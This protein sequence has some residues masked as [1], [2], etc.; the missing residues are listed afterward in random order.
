[1]EAHDVLED[2]DDARL[3]ALRS[4]GQPLKCLR[5]DQLEPGDDEICPDLTAPANAKH[6][7]AVDMRAALETTND[8]VEDRNQLDADL[9]HGYS[10]GYADEMPEADVRFGTE[11]DDREDY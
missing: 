10:R 8:D 6:L 9:A 2:Q 5:C 1:M 11:A 3:A 7:I 4:S